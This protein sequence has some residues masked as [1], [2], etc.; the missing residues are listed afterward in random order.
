[1]ENGKKETY[2]LFDKIAKY[3]DFLNHFLSLGV[4]IYWRKKLLTQIPLKNNLHVLDLA[5]GTADQAILLGKDEKVKSVIGIDLSK[6]MLDIGRKKVLKNRLQDKISLKEED[7][8]NTTFSEE[9]FDLIT[10]SFGLRNFCDLEKSFREAYRILKKNGR[11][12]ILELSIPAGIFK[13][14][15]LFYFRHILPAIGKALS[16][17]KNAYIYLN[18]S[19]EKF[20]DKILL[21]KKLEMAGFKN[22]TVTHLTMGIAAIYQADK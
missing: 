17:D 4:D 18:Q 22:I 20:P 21:Q 7:A 3:Y 10:V 6:K 2:K 16:K 9:H 12:L 19:V 13:K 14:P 15:Y 8:L 5:T 11:V 1:M